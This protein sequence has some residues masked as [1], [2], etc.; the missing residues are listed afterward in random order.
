MQ[1]KW[2]FP[3]RFTLFAPQIKSPMSRQQSQKLPFVGSNAFFHSYFFSHSFKLHG[4]PLSAA[5][6]LLRCLPKMS[7]FNSHTQK[8]AYTVLPNLKGIFEDALPRYCYVIKTKQQNNPLASFTT[9]LYRQ[10]R[11]WNWA[12]DSGPSPAGWPVVPARPFH[13]WPTSCCIHPILHFKNVAPFCFLSPPGFWP[14]C[15]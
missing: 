5:T 9:C 2:T 12:V 14:P 6:V 4:L 10:M 3:K 7:A 8:N 13:V 11:T 1:C 15:C